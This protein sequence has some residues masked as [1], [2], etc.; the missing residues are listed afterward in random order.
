MLPVNVSR[1]SSKVNFANTLL[2]KELPAHANLL[3]ELS[4]AMTAFYDDM[5]AR[6]QGDRVLMMTFSEFGR[7]AKENGSKGTDHGSGAP[8]FLVGG[9]VKS[10]IVGEHPSLTKMETGNL[11]HSIDF[12]RVY[13]AVLDHWL[14]VDSKSVLGDKYETLEVFEKS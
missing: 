2:G 1:M 14:G 4:G 6:G 12:R 7:R 9:K 8:M 13:A 5:K 10:G 11:I 3:A